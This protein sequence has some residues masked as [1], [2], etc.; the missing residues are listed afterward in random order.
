MS[1]SWKAEKA[2]IKDQSPVAKAALSSQSSSGIYLRG[3]AYLAERQGSRAAREFQANLDHVGVV[4]N[5]LMI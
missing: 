1:E 5:A 3:M 4:G 2:R